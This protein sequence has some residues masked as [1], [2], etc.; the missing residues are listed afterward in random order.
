MTDE[1]RQELVRKMRAGDREALAQLP[2]VV[3]S[4]FADPGAWNDLLR[5]I[6]QDALVPLDGSRQ[7]WVVPLTEAL[8]EATNRAWAN[9]AKKPDAE[10]WN[11]RMPW[12]TK[13]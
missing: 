12:P 3:M 9:R 8:M 5:T 7:W 11:R 4:T 2:D 13:T 10:Y 6:S 1:E